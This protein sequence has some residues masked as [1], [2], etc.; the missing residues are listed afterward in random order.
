MK[1]FENRDK[2]RNKFLK[3]IKE[4]GFSTF[5]ID[6]GRITEIDI[7]FEPEDY[8][9]LH[10]LVKGFGEACDVAGYKLFISTWI[11]EKIEDT[12]RHKV[13]VMLSFKD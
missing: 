3:I 9:K 8:T 13:R 2:F 12:Y 7:V 1:D 6:T 11:A 5:R 10:Y 4:E